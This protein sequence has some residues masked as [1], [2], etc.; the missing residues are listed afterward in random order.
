MSDNKKKTIFD[1]G[2]NIKGYVTD[3]TQTCSPMGNEIRATVKDADRTSDIHITGIIDPNLSPGDYVTVSDSGQLTYTTSSA[4]SN[5][6]VGDIT[7]ISTTID[8]ATKTYV[9]NVTNSLAWT[10][11]TSIG[12]SAIQIDPKVIKQLNIN[13]MMITALLQ[14]MTDEQRIAAFQKFIDLHSRITN[15]DGE[16]DSEKLQKELI[17]ETPMKFEEVVPDDEQ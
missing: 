8:A 1:M 16:I 14:T 17:R 6:I 12:S 7:N 10:W 15:D 11:D 4:N 3:I 9:D 2:A 5:T 13:S